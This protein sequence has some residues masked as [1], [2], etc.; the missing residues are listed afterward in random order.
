MGKGRLDRNPSNK[1]RR[2][3]KAR[4][5]K[6]FNHLS[7]HPTYW[8][9]ENPLLAFQLNIMLVVYVLMICMGSTN[10]H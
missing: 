9:T 8:N 10:K 2:R 6:F 3:R 5:L 7:K 4:A 1:A